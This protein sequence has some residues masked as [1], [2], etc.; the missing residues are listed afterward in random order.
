[1]DKEKLRSPFHNV[2]IS[3]EYFILK[4]GIKKK[5]CMH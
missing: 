5:E 3:V 1:M 2:T 4:E